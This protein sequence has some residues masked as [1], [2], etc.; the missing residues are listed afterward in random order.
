VNTKN[1]TTEHISFASVLILYPEKADCSWVMPAYI[2]KDALQLKFEKLARARA[3]R[4]NMSE[5]AVEASG[6]QH[7]AGCWQHPTSVLYTG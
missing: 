2:D 6:L 3:Y 7:I 5:E 1:V 4:Q